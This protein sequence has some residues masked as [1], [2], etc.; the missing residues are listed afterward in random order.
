MAFACTRP[1]TKDDLYRNIELEKRINQSSSE[2]I[3]L[4]NMNLTDQDIP[5]II[6]KGIKKKKPRSLSLSTNKITA[7]G[8]QMLV[9][10]I[11]TNKYLTHIFLSSNP[12]GDEGIKY[13]VELIRNNQNLHHLSLNDTGI[14][15]D[16]I[17]MITDVLASNSTSIRCLDLRSN[18]FI[19]DSSI[20]SLL[21][22][23]EQN[24][25]LSACRLDNCGLSQQGKEKLREA[26]LMKW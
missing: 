7:D 6:K 4:S 5:I 12:I 19:T 11:K 23:V 15:D 8:I 16:G 13:I 18:Q 22:I 21:Q 10:V 24:Q 25:T 14:T 3:D 1:K 20:D 9:D 26:K 2:N 17:R